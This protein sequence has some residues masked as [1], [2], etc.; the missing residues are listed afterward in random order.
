MSM[1]SMFMVLGR[2]GTFRY[3][4]SLGMLGW[5]CKAQFVRESERLP[6]FMFTLVFCFMSECTTPFRLS[7]ATDTISIYLLADCPKANAFYCAL[8]K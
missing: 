8:F 7:D 5:I 2:L 4:R 1:L 6:C 3:A